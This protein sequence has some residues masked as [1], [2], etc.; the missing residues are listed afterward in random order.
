MM[1]H[2]SIWIGAAA[3]AWPG[4]T[5]G[6]TL[7]FNGVPID[8]DAS[9][10]TGA[11]QT[12][13]VIDYNGLEASPTISESHAFLYRWDGT[14]TVQ[15]MLVAFDTA[16]TFDFTF[17][18]FTF[19]PGGGPITSTFLQDIVY[20]DPDGDAHSNPVSGNW[21]L[22]GTTDPL[23]P[24]DNW[25]S[26]TGGMNFETLVDGGIEG[27]N[28]AAF[29]GPPNFERISGPLD[30]PIIPE[31]ATAVLLIGSACVFTLRRRRQGVSA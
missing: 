7:L 12:L 15:D 31:P 3:L 5:L 11:Q 29:A 9:V 21:Q 23:L 6:D 27:L 19:D 16:G 30:V 2:A 22:A 14:Q 13:L 4:L 10:G 24:F 26:N 8:I 20:N 18:E 28:A 25:D 1:P 17:G